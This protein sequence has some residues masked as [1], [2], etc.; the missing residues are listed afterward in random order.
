MGMLGHARG[1]FTK[2]PGSCDRNRHF[3]EGEWYMGI[4]TTRVVLSHGATMRPFVKL[5][6]PLVCI[7]QYS[8]RM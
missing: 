7:C 4:S 6:R 5:L 1:R 3:W 2:G 8:V